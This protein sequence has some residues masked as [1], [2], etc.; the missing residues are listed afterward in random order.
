MTIV[1][2]GDVPVIRNPRMGIGKTKIR[3]IGK[4]QRMKKGGN[5]HAVNGRDYEICSIATNRIKGNRKK[6]T[7]TSP[8]PM[9][10]HP[11]IIVED[12]G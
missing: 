2:Q 4:N 9:T 5:I 1:F 8:N 12:N 10:Y 6:G 3:V 7:V 11:V